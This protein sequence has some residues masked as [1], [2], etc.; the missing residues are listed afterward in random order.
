MGGSAH[1]DVKLGWLE[2][3]A[4]G[5]LGKWIVKNNTFYETLGKNYLLS[6]SAFIY[7]S[8]FKTV[9]TIYFYSYQKKENIAFTDID[10]KALLSSVS[11]ANYTITRNKIDPKKIRYLRVRM[12][13]YFDQHAKSKF[14]F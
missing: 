6:I 12:E 2:F 7:A 5:R 1:M 9:T 4:N 3:S 11:K 8:Y 13:I 14:I 10:V